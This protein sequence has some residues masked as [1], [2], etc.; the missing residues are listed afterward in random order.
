MAGPVP[1]FEY[2]WWVKLSLLGVPG[3]KG[4]W[5][6]VLLSLVASVASVIYGFH[7]PRFFYV[8]GLFVCSAVLYW[9]SIRWVDRHGSWSSHG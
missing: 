6:F 4:L 8:A 3:R 5:S 1:R 9:S 7:D 2:P